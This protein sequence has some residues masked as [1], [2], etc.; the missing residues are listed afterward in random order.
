LAKHIFPVFTS[1]RGRIF[2]GRVDP[3]G[4]LWRSARRSDLL[5][6]DT[7]TVG[8]AGMEKP[9]TDEV[10]REFG[11]LA[12]VADVP[13]GRKRDA[14]DFWGGF[15]VD[16]DTEVDEEAEGGATVVT[17]CSAGVAFSSQAGGA[18]VST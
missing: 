9:T 3:I 11:D 1:P 4:T 8:V 17:G 18:T 2:G 15:D 10:G 13:V 16:V 7:A 5:L 12:D 14:Q 6:G